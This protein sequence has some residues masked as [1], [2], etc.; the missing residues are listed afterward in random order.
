MRFLQRGDSV[1]CRAAA[2]RNRTGCGR[3]GFCA[4][5]HRIDQVA[6]HA[7]DGV[8]TEADAVAIDGEAAAETLMSGGRTLMPKR[9]HSEVYSIT[10]DV[11]SSTLVSRA[12]MNSVG[13]MALE[14]G[15]LEGHVGV[16]GRVGLVEGVGGK[17]D[18]IIVDLVCHCLRDAVFDA[19]S[20][21]LARLGAS[22]DKMLA[23]GLHDPGF[24]CS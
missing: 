16:A 24:F 18:H 19:A 13:V 22:M 7:F 12:A 5:Y 4:L 11:L 23:L 9:W 15:C 3:G 17:T 14:V 21:L 6:A 2:C 8:E 20:A 1:R 10:F